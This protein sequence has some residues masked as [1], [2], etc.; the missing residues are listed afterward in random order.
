MPTPEFHVNIHECKEVWFKP[1]FQKKC[2]IKETE[3]RSIR[4]NNYQ[5]LNYLSKD[6]ILYDLLPIICLKG[7]CP[8]T[9]NIGRPLYTDTNH[10]TDFANREYIYKDFI[11]FLEEKEL[12]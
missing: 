3:L 4:E 1:F 11:N 2:L 9:D 6:I 8:M 5:M 12:I 7:E 10:F